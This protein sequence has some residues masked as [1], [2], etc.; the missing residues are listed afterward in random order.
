MFEKIII[1][2][3]TVILVNLPYKGRNFKKITLKQ[4]LG[5]SLL[6]LFGSL[7]LIIL[8]VEQIYVRFNLFT[9][10]VFLLV[11]LF[12]FYISKLVR[13]YGKYPTDYLNDKKNNMRF[14][15]KLEPLTLTIKYFEVL[16]QQAGFLYVFF[17]VL[18]GFDTTVK[19]LAFTI[20]VGV[21]HLGNILFM[22]LKWTLIYFALSIPMAMLFGYLLSEGYVLVT[23][24]IHLLFYTISN[25]LLWLKKISFW[26]LNDLNSRIDER[27]KIN[28]L[29]K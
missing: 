7:G 25:A 18:N 15:A 12:W 9:V 10:I 17:G 22:N 29:K 1:F 19:V 6:F 2:L 27:V 23:A 4:T 3:I 5:I 26:W 11:S 21:L 20:V 16:F 13:R 28:L 24:G 14:M 8:V